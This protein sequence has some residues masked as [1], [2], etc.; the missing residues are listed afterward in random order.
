[1]LGNATPHIRTWQDSIGNDRGETPYYRICSEEG[2]DMMRIIDAHIRRRL[3][4]I[5]IHQ[6]KRPRFLY[7]HLISR[8]VPPT[9]A[10]KTAFIRRGTWNRSNRPGMTRAYPNNWFH[11]RLESLWMRWVIFNPPPRVSRDPQ[12]V[13]ALYLY[14]LTTPRFYLGGDWDSEG[15]LKDGSGIIVGHINFSQLI[16]K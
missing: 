13:F 2:A 10:A 4:A 6:K 9:M 7:R 1:V 11:E 12:L 16:N 14:D 8:G 5:V 3:R 15:E